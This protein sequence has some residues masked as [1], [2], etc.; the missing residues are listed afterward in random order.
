TVLLRRLP[1]RL[2]WA[3]EAGAAARLRAGSLNL[4]LF[5]VRALAQRPLVELARLGP[6][7]AGA[8]RRNEPVVV[9]ALAGLELMA[10]GLRAPTPT[11]SGAG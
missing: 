7:P 4:E 9:E 5:A 11:S 6:D 3:R 10:L 8:Y 2:R 1:D